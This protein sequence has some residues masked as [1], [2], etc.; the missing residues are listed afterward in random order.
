[1]KKPRRSEANG[2]KTALKSGVFGVADSRRIPRIEPLD[3]GKYRS[4]PL[5]LRKHIGHYLR[6]RVVLTLPVSQ[7]RNTTISNLRLIRHW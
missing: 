7:G 2:N 3:L 6:I 4:E 5:D 1:M